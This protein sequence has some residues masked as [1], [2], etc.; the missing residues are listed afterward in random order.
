MVSFYRNLCL[1]DRGGLWVLP[2]SK[3]SQEVEGFLNY[4]F[5]SIETIKP[6]QNKHWRGST[7]DKVSLYRKLGEL[8]QESR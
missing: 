2:L 5:K 3:D 8:P 6:P 4:K 7:D 1:T